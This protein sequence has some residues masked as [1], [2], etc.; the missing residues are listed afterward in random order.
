M[1]FNLI[2]SCPQAGAAPDSE[3]TLSLSCSLDSSQL[4]S[5]TMPAAAGGSDGSAPVV[6][7]DTGTGFVKAGFA[8]DN[9]PRA[10]FHCMVGRPTLRHG[11]S[12]AGPQV[13]KVRGE[14]IEVEE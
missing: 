6:V 5:S 9:F 13:L 12:F 10:S 2:L 4:I 1:L 11:E 8:G 14:E 7:L 3:C